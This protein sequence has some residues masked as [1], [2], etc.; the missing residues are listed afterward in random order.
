MV[1]KQNESDKNPAPPPIDHFS[2]IEDSEDAESCKPFNRT[3]INGD[4]DP[5]YSGPVGGPSRGNRVLK[6]VMRREWTDGMKVC[7]DIFGKHRDEF[8]SDIELASTLDTVDSEHYM[9]GVFERR[10]FQEK[11]EDSDGIMK[12]VE[13]RRAENFLGTPYF[14][15]TYGSVD[16]FGKRSA[17]SG[18]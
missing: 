4:E 9:R 10:L 16:M 7:R 5:R 6:P 11:F 17:K 12:R 1:F 15:F 3:L 8:R 13:V 18:K 14:V 2:R